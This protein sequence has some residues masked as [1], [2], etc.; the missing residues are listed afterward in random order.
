MNRE[1]ERYTIRAKSYDEIV[2]EI[3]APF[4]ALFAA[5]CQPF[6]SVYELIISD[7]GC[8][9]NRSRTGK[10]NCSDS[11]TQQAAT[12]RERESEREY[13]AFDD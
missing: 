8:L 13:N 12:G 3:V 11:T 5:C 7:V 6:M 1:R 2:V 10:C 4:H 9:I